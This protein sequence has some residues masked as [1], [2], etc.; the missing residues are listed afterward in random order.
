MT[1]ENLLFQWKM[2]A[3]LL[4][5]RRHSSFQNPVKSFEKEFLSSPLFA[6][7]CPRVGEIFL[8]PGKKIFRRRT[9]DATFSSRRSS[10]LFI[11]EPSVHTAQLLLFSP[12]PFALF[13]PSSSVS[14]FF[15]LCLFLRDGKT[16]LRA[17]LLGRKHRPMDFCR[18]PGQR[19]RIWQRAL[20]AALK[21][22]TRRT[23]VADGEGWDKRSRRVVSRTMTDGPAWF[24]PS[25]QTHVHT[26]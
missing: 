11:S 14:S 8:I 7:E 12:P 26:W 9:D 23:Q 20:I 25:G 22:V 3:Y 17:G 24:F 13:R 19:Q 6:E 21:K 18:V 1:T 5:F 15:C 16:R 10:S 2:Q 4:P